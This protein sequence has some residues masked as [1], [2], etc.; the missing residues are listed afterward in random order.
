MILQGR[1]EDHRRWTVRGFALT[2]GLAFAAVV[3]RLVLVAALGR[4][5]NSALPAW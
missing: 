1:I 4:V 5:W 3:L 2:F